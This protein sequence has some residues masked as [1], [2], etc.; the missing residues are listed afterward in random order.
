MKKYLTKRNLS[1]AALIIIPLVI[2]IALGI[3]NS[4]SDT[5]IMCSPTPTNTSIDTPTPTGGGS[6][7]HIPLPPPPSPIPTM[8]LDIFGQCS[9]FCEESMIGDGHC[10]PFCNNE[11]CNYD[12]KDC[13]LR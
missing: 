4:V 12:E 1:I 10:D 8:K 13:G 2:I 11:D 5:C 6:N 9:T 3:C 7:T